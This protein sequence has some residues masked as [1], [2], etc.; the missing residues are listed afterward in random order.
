MKNKP[1]ILETNIVAGAEFPNIPDFIN[2][3]EKMV[4]DLQCRVK[5]LEDQQSME[6]ENAHN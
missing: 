3:L 1:V 2:N 4:K 6:K 5:L